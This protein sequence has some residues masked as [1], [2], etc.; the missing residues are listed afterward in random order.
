MFAR[1]FFYSLLIA[2]SYHVVRSSRNVLWN[3]IFNVRDVLIGIRFYNKGTHF[4]GLWCLARLRIILI[5]LDKILPLVYF[6]SLSVYHP[7]DIW[8]WPL[9]FFGFHRCVVSACSA[10][11]NIGFSIIILF[12]FFEE[13]LNLWRIEIEWRLFINGLLIFLNNFFNYFFRVN[14][15]AHS[16]DSWPT[17]INLLE[18]LPNFFFK[19]LVIFINGEV[20]ANLKL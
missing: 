6:F 2:E 16:F 3:I 11:K 15:L 18:R 19:C 1:W 14:I 8:T 9:N 4:R 7:A 10:S 20:P 5:D 17:A 13:F 12:I